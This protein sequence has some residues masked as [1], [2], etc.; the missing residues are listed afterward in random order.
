MTLKTADTVNTELLISEMDL[1]RQWQPNPVF[2]LG[3]HHGQKS[4]VGY[5]P[6][7]HKQVE[8]TEHAHTQRWMVID[9]GIHCHLHSNP[10]HWLSESKICWGKHMTCKQV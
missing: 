10:R 6:W 5:S 3:K 1:R 7:G 8:A 9:A 2:L 4:L